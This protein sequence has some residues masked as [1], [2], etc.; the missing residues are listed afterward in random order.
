[1]AG[2]LTDTA[3]TRTLDWLTGNSTTAPTLPLKAR[4]CTTHG[5]DSAAG[6][7]VVGGSYA[8]PTAAFGAASGTSPATALNTGAITASGLPTAV[9][10][11]VEIWDSAGSPVRWSH[12]PLSPLSYS[13]VA[14]TDVFTAAAHGMANGDQ[15]S[16]SAAEVPAG[17]TANTTY[18]VVNQAT[19]TFQLAATNGGAALTTVSADRTG[20]LARE[21]A[22]TTGDSYTIPIGSFSL[23]LD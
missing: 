9:L 4:F 22:V 3:E 15:V 17:L 20:V 18:Y 11:S 6:T 7:E 14:S 10:R 19:N 21:K 23:S 12:G 1:M 16:F 2:N 8:A 5:S 13:V